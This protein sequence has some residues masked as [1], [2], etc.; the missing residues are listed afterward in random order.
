MKKVRLKECPFCGS[1]AGIEYSD[2]Q[3]HPFCPNED[4]ILCSVN[5]GFDSL[6]EAVEAWNMRNENDVIYH[7][8]NL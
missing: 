7:S 8:I 1:K 2:N 4:C 5:Y 3:Y 6:E